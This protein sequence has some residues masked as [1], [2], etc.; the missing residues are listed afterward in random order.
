LTCVWNP[1]DIN[2]L[3]AFLAAVPSCKAGILAYNGAESVKLGERLW[4][5]PLS[6]LV[7]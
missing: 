2:G 7:S 4:A 6:L 3:K 5:I 1:K